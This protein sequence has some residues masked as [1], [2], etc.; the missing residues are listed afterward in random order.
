MIFKRFAA[1]LRAQ[2]WFAIGIELAIVILGVFVGTWVANW[3]QERAAQRDT[4][5]LLRELGPEMIAQKRAINATREYFATTQRYATTAFAGWRGDPAV[6]DSD[7]VIAAYQASQA[8][9]LDANGQAWTTIFGGDQLRRIGDPAIRAPL[10]RLM[11]FEYSI[12]S[13]RMLM[14]RYRDDVRLV[15]PDEAQ[16]MIRKSCGD[17]LDSSGLNLKLPAT[18]R[19]V[20]PDAARI[21]AALRAQPELIGKLAQHVGAVSTQVANVDLFEA[22]VDALDKGIKRLG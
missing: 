5:A 15:I 21:A 3:N 9:G 8:A 14:T 6:S 10:Q 12:L 18:C 19:I 20:V 7:F 1:N 2:N 17:H 22:Q 13:Y 16:Q 11:T 4:Q